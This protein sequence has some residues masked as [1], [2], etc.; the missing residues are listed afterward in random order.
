MVA[1]TGA[2]LCRIP[3]D[4]ASSA[5]SVTESARASASQS[6]LLVQAI[7]HQRREMLRLLLQGLADT[8]PAVREIAAYALCDVVCPQ[9]GEQGPSSSG[10]AG[11]RDAEGGGHGRISGD[12]ERWLAAA[13]SSNSSPGLRGGAAKALA[14][15]AARK[16]EPMSRKL[17]IE[18]R[19]LPTPSAPAS[20]SSLPENP[21]PRASEQA[22]GASGVMQAIEL[23]ADDGEDMEGRMKCVCE[24]CTHWTLDRIQQYLPAFV[25]CAVEGFASQVSASFLCSVCVCA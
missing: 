22:T 5:R 17:L 16:S 4:V 24:M 11:A 10:S 13:L 9:P 1:I 21:T 20:P 2:L 8:D 25:S 19:L 6:K 15:L 7:A 18:L 14:L 23:G 12:V 3:A